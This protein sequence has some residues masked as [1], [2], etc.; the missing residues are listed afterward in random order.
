MPI[1]N[2]PGV[3]SSNVFFCTLSVS[4]STGD[5]TISP[6]DSVVIK[7]N[8][9]QAD[10]L[11]EWQN[12]TGTVLGLINQNGYATF[13]GNTSN[14][15]AI[16]TLGASSSGVA[17]LNFTSGF[18][19]SAPNTGDMW[20][21]GTNLFFYDGTQSVDLLTSGGG[22]S[23]VLSVYGSVANAGYLNLAHDTNSY[24]VV[25]D[26]WI[27][28]GGSASE[29]CSGGNWKN[30]TDT[31]F[32]MRESLSNQWNDA[33]SDGIIRSV[34]KLTD[35]ELAPGI[36]VGTGADGDI[37]VI[38]NTNI[39]TTSLATGRNCADGGDAVNYNVTTFNAAGTEATLSTTP[40]TGC[41]NVGDE[42]LIINLQGTTSAYSNVGN[43]ET[44]RISNVSGTT[45]TFQTAKSNY[46][47]NNAGDDSN[48]GTTTG[49]QRVILQ[50]IP[51][52]RNVSINSGYTFYP[53]S[54][55]GTN[56]GIMSFR[57][58][59]TVDV[60]GTISVSAV[61]YRGGV[62]GT[63]VSGCTNY[64]YPTVAGDR[65][66]TV[67]N[68]SVV[69]CSRTASVL[70]NTN[71]L[72]ASYGGGGGGGAGTAAP[73]RN[74][75]GGGGGTYAYT[76]SSGT[77]SSTGEK[78]GSS[79]PSIYG[80]SN[81][82]SLYF[83][84]GG[85]GGGRG[86]N[87]YGGNGG[88]GGGI[89]YIN[90]TTFN[91]N[92]S[93]VANGGNGS[94]GA[95][96]SD[97]GGGGAGAGAGGSVLL[98]AVNLSLGSNKVSA[99]GGS[100]GSGSTG[101]YG[102]GGN[103]GAGG[104][105]RIAVFYATAVTG[106]TTPTY[107][108]ASVGNYSYGVYTSSVIS[109]PNAQSYDNITWDASLNTYGKISVQTRSGATSDSTDGTWEEWRPYTSGTN[110]VTVQSADTHTDFTGTNATV[111]E[112]DIGRFVDYFEDEDESTTT[113]IT[114]MTSST[115]GGYMEA[116]ISST[117]LSTYDYLTL[118]VRASQTG[119]VLRIGMGES[120]G[121]EQ[122]EDITIDAAN[123]WQKV[124]WDLSDITSTDRDAI[125]KVRLTNFSTNS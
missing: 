83:G 80:S 74:G 36:N 63:I 76:G 13:G 84:S 119:N 120:A 48:L 20:W 115:N 62:G 117:D 2:D 118:W 11:M 91:N 90:A 15:S 86:V 51:N 81:L 52:Y 107:S 97:D 65:G 64:A 45:V 1:I 94:N 37:I 59:G 32:T 114:K 18:D 93:V 75:G 88:T 73:N 122:Y 9:T 125:T 4:N 26:G 57:A 89:I 87:A 67:Y 16:L 113:N 7:A 110:Y 50:R 68:A 66:E 103:G 42:V 124:Y 98:R 53:S 56:G 60:S 121:T 72:S 39:N 12:S 102:T 77:A 40:S 22:G 85:G 41:L 5:I 47:G 123:T 109:T 38:S 101:S 14:T 33:D 58:S 61:G 6:D 30:I 24:D 44:L 111:A 29:S 49:S 55:N 35:V 92:G 79:G 106:T 70:G 31:D 99:T 78:G 34:I 19:V 116:T 95:G 104:V 23:D 3:I 43:Y 17:Q 54:W 82:F 21:N 25:A 10:N 96:G 28:V 71:A 112:G 8:D 105:G 46:Y 27:C 108:G 69:G 100:G